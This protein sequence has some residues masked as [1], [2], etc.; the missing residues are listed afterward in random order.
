LG[1]KDAN[2]FAFVAIIA[3]PVGMKDASMQEMQ[4]ISKGLAV[5]E[6]DVLQ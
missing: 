6:V 3:K 4:K 2:F 1:S 5:F